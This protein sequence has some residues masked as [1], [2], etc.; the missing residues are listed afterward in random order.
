[1]QNKVKEFNQKLGHKELNVQ[2][3]LLDIISEAGELSKEVVKACEYGEKSFAVNENFELELGDVLY[4][5][6]SLCNETGV[7]AEEV[8]GKVIKKYEKRFLDKGN[9]GSGN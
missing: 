4:A 6:L 7:N 3:R 1:M 2:M 5:L 8:L 9:I